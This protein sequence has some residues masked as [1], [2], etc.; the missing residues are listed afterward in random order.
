M[1]VLAFVYDDYYCNGVRSSFRGQYDDAEQAK[2]MLNG[3][4]WERQNLE[5]LDLDT[6]KMTQ[7]VWRPLYEYSDEYLRSEDN[8]EI[9]HR[10]FLTHRWD[11]DIPVK[12]IFWDGVRK[13]GPNQIYFD[14]GEWQ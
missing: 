3:G 4:R 13:Y 5:L 12:E 1:T 14:A 6:L 2:E 7:H 8:S 10:E 11:K 9:K